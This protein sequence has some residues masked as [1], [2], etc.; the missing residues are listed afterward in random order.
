MAFSLSGVFHACIKQEYIITKFG[1]YD[2][3]VYMATSHSVNTTRHVLI[4]AA[5]I[6]FQFTYSHGATCAGLVKVYS[7]AGESY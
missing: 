2:P 1:M 5:N 7:C 3:H 4:A 6:A